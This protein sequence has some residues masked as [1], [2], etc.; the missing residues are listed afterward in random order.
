MNGCACWCFL[1]YPMKSLTLYSSLLN[2]NKVLPANFSASSFGTYLPLLRVLSIVA[3]NLSFILTYSLNLSSFSIRFNKEEYK[4]SDF[5]GYIKKHQQAQPFMSAASYAYQLYDEFLKE[6]A[7]A[8]EDAHLEEKYPDFKLLVQE[9]HDGILLFDLMEKEVWKKAELDTAGINAYYEEHKNDFMWDKRV[10][11]IIMTANSE[12][13]VTTAEELIRRDIP[14]DSIKA[15]VRES[16]KK[17]DNTYKGITVKSP[18]FQQGDNVDVDETEWVAGTI[19]VIPS[20]VDNFTKIIKIVE[21]RDP[22]PKTFKE[23]R[24]LITSAYQTK[25][26]EDWLEALKEKYP[27]TVD[28]KILEKVKKCYNN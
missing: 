1:I 20:T 6:T 18:Y 2:L 3:M 5:I 11:T 24:G 16:N 22:E 8:Y 12:E 14:A 10:K 13:S 9:Y 27:V 4:V 15:I 25:L 17:G 28:E 7:F 23:A 19:R 26:E 21:V